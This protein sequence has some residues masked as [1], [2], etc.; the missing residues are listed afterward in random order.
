MAKEVYINL[1]KFSGQEATGEEKDFIENM[2]TNLGAPKFDKNNKPTIHAEVINRLIRGIPFDNEKEKQT[3]KPVKVHLNNAIISDKLDLSF[4]HCNCDEFAP[5]L[6]LNNCEIAEEIDLSRAKIKYLNLAGCK[7]TY[8]NGVGLQ[9]DGSIDMEGL[10]ADSSLIGETEVDTENDAEKAR[11]GIKLDNALIKGNILANNIN[12]KSINEYCFIMKYSIVLGSLE[13]GYGSFDGGIQIKNATIGGDI[14]GSGSMFISNQEINEAIDAQAISCEGFLY[15]S[16]IKNRIIKPTVITGSIR[17]LHAHIKKGIYLKGTQIKQNYNNKMFNYSILLSLSTIGS[18]VYL[19]P[20]VEDKP[21]TKCMRFTAKGL[22]D[23]Q[24]AN[25]KGSLDMNGA[26]IKPIRGKHVINASNVHIGKEVYLSTYEKKKV[27]SFGLINLNNATINGNLEV[28]DAELNA[29]LMYEGFFANDIT[30]KGNIDFR[31]NLYYPAEFDRAKV[32]GRFI[33]GDDDGKSICCYMGS[34]QEPNISLRGAN[35]GQALRVRNFQVERTPNKYYEETGQT[36]LRDPN[37]KK[38]KNHLKGIRRYLLNGILPGWQLTHFIFNNYKGYCTSISCL[39]KQ[40]KKELII[41]DGSSH[42]INNLVRRQSFQIK[43]H[44]DKV[45]SSADEK[46]AKKYIKFYC[47]YIWGRNQPFYIIDQNDPMDFLSENDKK[48][49]DSKKIDKTL[50]CEYRKEEN[51]FEIIATGIF[52]ERLY[53]FTFHVEKNGS[54]TMVNDLNKGKANINIDN[55]KYIM[56][57]F[58]DSEKPYVSKTEIC[59]YK[60]TQSMQPFCSFY[61][62]CSFFRSKDPLENTCKNTQQ[63]C[64]LIKEVYQKIQ[65]E[66]K[67]KSKNKTNK[68]EQELREL[69]YNLINRVDIDLTRAHAGALNDQSGNGWGDMVRLFLDGFTYKHL[70]RPE[71]ASVDLMYNR[72]KPLPWLR[73]V[74]LRILWQS[75]SWIPNLGISGRQC[76]LP[77]FYIAVVLAASAITIYCNGF[78]ITSGLLIL[79]Y[80]KLHPFFGKRFYNRFFIQEKAIPPKEVQGYIA[81]KLIKLFNASLKN[82]PTGHVIEEG[83]DDNINWFFSKPWKWRSKWLMMQYRYFTPNGLE[84]VLHPYRQ[85]E[86]VYTAQGQNED[87]RRIALLR[88]KFERKRKPICFR[89]LL[90]PYEKLFGSGLAPGRAFLALI[91]Y[92]IIGSIWFADLSKNDY[93]IVDNVPVS[94]IEMV[95]EAPIETEAAEEKGVK[96]LGVL[97]YEQTNTTEQKPPAFSSETNCGDTINPWIYSLD[98]MIPL[99]DFRQ[100]FRCQIKPAEKIPGEGLEYAENILEQVLE[101]NSSLQL[102]FLKALYTIFGW[103]TTALTLL[104]MTGV[105]RKHADMRSITDDQ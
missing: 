17:L 70:T 104:T 96:I 81:T 1:W 28:K 57:I 6:I 80:F 71:I 73:V 16:S 69:R 61:R 25:I 20:A 88:L 31:P 50:R 65:N 45:N 101:K 66:R 52:G 72:M 59:S 30:V 77:I 74:W 47:T 102:L 22:I 24:E 98:V 94:N 23:L 78:G 18:D 54:V 46:Y 53:E 43:E 62:D 3:V 60:H 44:T 37:G 13:L 49:L 19:S 99:I 21:S 42:A 14:W 79:F 86:R 97:S 7:I 63:T 55:H 36:W 39:Q 67:L 95:T 76:L 10:Q 5:P 84:F 34:Q 85:L 40:K 15:L 87:A 103:L 93:M 29:H 58:N 64:Y 26:I 68:I 4:L 89:L 90:W 83:S 82:S 51:I 11:T 91:A 9:V 8:L 12:L 48:K 35:I 27:K 92:W 56:A 41:L 38:I 100:E 2:R 75:I 33:L 32:G 105:L